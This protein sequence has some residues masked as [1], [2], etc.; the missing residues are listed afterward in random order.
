MKIPRIAAESRVPLEDVSLLL[1]LQSFAR[2]SNST[3]GR[4]KEKEKK[5]IFKKLHIFA[6]FYGIN[7]V[8]N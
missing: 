1:A 8:S 7:E 2:Q 3:V 4:K 5:L 6:R